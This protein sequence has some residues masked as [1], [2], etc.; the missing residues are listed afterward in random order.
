MDPVRAVLSVAGCLSGSATA[1]ALA[2]SPAALGNRDGPNTP[3]ARGVLSLTSPLRAL[4]VTKS[5]IKPY[6]HGL[7]CHRL[8]TELRARAFGHREARSN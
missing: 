6:R 5:I 1:R 2:R 7:P 3:V 8:S 4:N